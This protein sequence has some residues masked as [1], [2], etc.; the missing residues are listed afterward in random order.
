MKVAIFT[1]GM[2]RESTGIGRYT[3]ELLYAMHDRDPSVEFVLI[4]PYR[5]SNLSMYRDFRTIC[6]P[7]LRRLP[8]VLAHGPWL[9]DRIAT[10]ER[11]DVLHDPCGIAPFV[12]PRA[13]RSYA[14]LT[15]I[16]DAVPYRF[17]STQPLL[18]RIIFRTWVPMSRWTSDAVL[19]VSECSQNDLV[20]LI[21]IPKE[22]ITVTPLGIRMPLHD[23]LLEWRR[24]R[25]KVSA[26]LGTNDDYI[27]YVGALNPRK[28]LLRVLEVFGASGPMRER[29]LVVVGPK[30]WMADPVLRKAGAF[31]DRVI[32][33]GYVD[34]D[35]LHRLYANALL[36][37]YPSLYEGFG[38]PALEGMAHGI[39]VV[40]S[41]T[42]S[43]PEVCGQAAVL[44]D[45]T[46][47]EAIRSAMEMLLADPYRLKVLSIAGRQRAS[48]FTW[49]LAATKTLGV[50]RS[51]VDHRA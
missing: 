22:L 12:F 29:R 2:N 3:S 16:H 39:P 7:S 27:L 36:L 10:Q 47:S 38:L 26:L 32:L 37:V 1:Y 43:L 6:T 50:Y 15:T 34:D 23:E 9:L 51:I 24:E 5:D 44:V 13:R 49:D 4:N 21:G 8:F 14:R 20:N 42:S 46:D 19:T 40:T 30:T 25:S 11:V 31:G 33:T 41:T 17:A 18:T 28:N 45:P 48:S 35:M